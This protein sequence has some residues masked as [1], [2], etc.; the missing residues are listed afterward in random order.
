MVSPS[1][2]LQSVFARLVETCDETNFDLDQFNVESLRVLVVDDSQTVRQHVTSVLSGLGIHHIT[3]AENGAEA[4]KLINNRT[5]NLVVTDYH[6]PQVDGK[7]LTHYIRQQSDQPTIP[8]LMV[9]SEDD[10]QRLAE[11]EF[12]GVSGICDK[13]FETHFVRELLARILTKEFRIF[14]GKN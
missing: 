14:R 8:I 4:I 12:E 7:A 6:M 11:I 2:A 3:E 5:F 13:S 1:P 9:T 10:K